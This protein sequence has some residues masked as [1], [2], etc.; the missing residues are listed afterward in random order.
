MSESVSQSVSQSVRVRQS[1]REFLFTN[2]M[3]KMITIVIRNLFDLPF[4]NQ[5]FPFEKR[6][7]IKECH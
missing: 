2:V 1:Y 4:E 7:A 3:R 6:N 5:L